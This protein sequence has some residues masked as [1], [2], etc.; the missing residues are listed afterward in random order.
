MAE[1]SIDL[2]AMADL[3]KAVGGAR[4]DITF[5]AGSIAGNLD[6]V[7]L[8]TQPLTAARYDNEID[9]WLASSERDLNRRLS[10]ARLIATSD[11]TMS[12]VTYDDSVLS[13]ATDAEI[14]TRV[15]RVAELM[16]ID[17]DDLDPKAIDPEL[18]ELLGDNALDPY[19]AKALAEKVSPE[20][21]DRYLQRVNMTAMSPQQV[22]QSLEDYKKSYDELVGDLGAVFGLASQGTGSLEVKGMAQQWA[23]LITKSAF[24]HTGTAN[25]LSVIVGR[26]LWSTDFLTTTFKAIRDAE[27]DG[28]TW[29]GAGMM[30]DAFEPGQDIPGYYT[31]QDPLKGWFRAMQSSPQA[32][33]QLFATGP[34]TTIEVDGQ[35]VQVNKE[36]YELMHDRAWAGDGGITPDG[37]QAIAAFTD[38]IRAAIMSPPV[39][40]QQAFQPVLAHDLGAIAQL[41]DAE[42]KEAEEK[43]GPVW[44]QIV[45]G[46]ADLIGLV[47]IVGDA[48]D[49]V[50]GLTYFARGDNVNGALSM[51]AVVPFAGWAATGGKW[52]RE[53]VKAE[54]I[55]ELTAKGAQSV[56]VARIFGKDGKLLDEGI[57]L[58]DPSN[59]SPSRWL[60]PTEQRIFSGN[61]EFIGRMIAGNRFNSFAN[62]NYKFS[63]ISMAAG[64]SGHYRLDAWTPGEAIVSR[65]LTQL[66][67]VTA[68]TAKGYIDEFVKKYP[69][70]AVLAD[71]AKNRELGIAGQKLTGDMVLEVPPQVGG[72]ISDTIKEYAESQG[73]FIR[74]IN[75]KWYTDPPS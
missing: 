19:F 58:T 70:G 15:D 60:S 8:S 27:K 9:Q 64:K 33:A 59:F 67:G 56:T 23:D 48:V 16:K 52:V 5:A 44:V 53:A 31:I 30:N 46:V 71:T 73:V 4:T 22:D 62:A 29:P 13:T 14:K 69:N 74:D 32:M 65:K 43:R 55:A 61:R 63:E 40:G 25:R 57:D 47:P 12:V 10:M 39:A 28:A 45:D 37:E 6:S 1:V 72:K 20:M 54:E 3:V 7:W 17:D 35:K 51:G 75:G 50:H 36:L 18:L 42:A 49:F 21:L 24:A 41:L 34:M 11:P 2:D 38:A 26:G 66:D 68:D